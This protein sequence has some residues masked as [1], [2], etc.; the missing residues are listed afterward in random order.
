MSLLVPSQTLIFLFSDPDNNLSQTLYQSL[1]SDSRVSGSSTFPELLPLLL[2]TERMRNP[3]VTNL[4]LH[5][6]SDMV[7]RLI[8]TRR[9]DI[10]VRA[11]KYVVSSHP[12]FHS[13]K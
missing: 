3:S 2:E 4:L 11:L 8:D 6:A 10:V 13:L 7:P 5:L 1:T 9:V 12:Y